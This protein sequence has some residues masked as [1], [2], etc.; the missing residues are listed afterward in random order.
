[1]RQRFSYFTFSYDGNWNSAMLH[2]PYWLHSKIGSCSN[3]L[4]DRPA[5][6]ERDTIPSQQYTASD[7]VSINIAIALSLLPLTPHIGAV[8]AA[9]IG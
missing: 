4:G 6:Q 1:M 8:L 9:A 3:K 5:L 2:P 7:P